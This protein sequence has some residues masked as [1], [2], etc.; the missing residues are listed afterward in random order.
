MINIFLAEDHLVV[1]RG[2]KLLLDTQE[3]MRVIAEAENGTEVL[4][5]LA[6]GKIPDILI[7]DI[8]MPEMDGLELTNILS[9]EYPSIKIIALSMLNSSLDMTKA[10]DRGVKGYLVKNVG[11]DELLFA[12]E[13]V[14]QGGMYMCEE[15]AFMLLD[16][17][18]TQPDQNCMS[19]ETVKEFDLSERELEV[20]QLIGE[21]YTNLE[22]ADKLFLS[23]RTIEGHRQSLIDK[24][25]TKNSASLIKFAV[26]HG[27]IV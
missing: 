15:L 16:K 2:I 3:N 1:R 6:Q 21:G 12:I 19:E 17:V 26:K 20:L 10:F 24:T 4:D 25:K 22:I 5:K 8:T 27:I 14:H 7:T 18:K 9:R 13:Y 23:K 11:Y